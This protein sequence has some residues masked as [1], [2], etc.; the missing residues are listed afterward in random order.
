[1]T[2]PTAG[3]ATILCA[4]TAPRPGLATR[5]GTAQAF[6]G[7]T[8][9]V[10]ALGD[11]IIEP[12]SDGS[13]GIVRRLIEAYD[14][15][16]RAAAVAVTEVAATDV[17]RYGIVVAG[18]DGPVLTVSEIVEKPAPGSVPSRLAIAA[19]YVIGPE[20]FA[21]L[22]D[23]EPDADG[24]VQLADGAAAGDRGRRAGGGGAARAR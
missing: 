24:E 22:R 1:M 6:A 21:A 20:V 5:C 17:S 15:T 18:G 8:G 13:P 11:A 19:R 9:A 12:P 3:P 2:P 7:T 14:R 16:G 10:V 23:A 4:P